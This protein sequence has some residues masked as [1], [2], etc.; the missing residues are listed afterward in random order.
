M[1]SL[2]TEI[3]G[4]SVAYALLGV[5]LLTACLF[6]RLPWPFK[7]G[8]I[9][10]TSM[11]YIVSFYA[12]RGLL[13]WSSVDPLPP[14]FK[15]LH[16]RI[17]EPHSLAGDPAPS[18]YGSRRSTTTTGQAASPVPIAC[19]TTPNSRKE[20]KRQSRRAPMAA[21]RADARPM[22]AL[23]KAVRARSQRG[24]LRR[25]RSPQLAAAILQPEDRW[26]RE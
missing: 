20:P 4:L 22:S 19:P 15:L 24:K 7:A 9:V 26:I 18:I 16:A 3:V 12:A 1:I 2:T 8:C 6:T 11:F 5:L 25:V 21:R 23:A 13:G 14:R 17:V 10:L